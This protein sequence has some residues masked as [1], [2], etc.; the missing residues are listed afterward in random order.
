MNRERELETRAAAD[1][2]AADDRELRWVEDE[3]RS[4]AERSRRR[5][6]PPNAAG[7]HSCAHS[8]VVGKVASSFKT[9]R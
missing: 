6:R 4:R 2:R 8:T 1:E 7:N 9:A 5:D 3:Y